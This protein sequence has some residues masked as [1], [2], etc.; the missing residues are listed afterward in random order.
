MPCASITAAQVRFTAADV[1]A[2]ALRADGALGA[3]VSTVQ[4]AVAGLG[5]VPD[6]DVACTEKLCGPSVRPKKAAGLVQDA[7]GALS[8]RHWNVA[9]VWVAWN[10]NV[11]DVAL[12]MAAGPL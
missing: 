9:G 7:A 1:G 10:M 8:S 2:A 3:V 4:V 11:A 5:S 6:A 12:V